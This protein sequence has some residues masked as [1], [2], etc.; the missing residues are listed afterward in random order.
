M[1]TRPRL[2]IVVA[3]VMVVAAGCATTVER[4]VGD[5]TIATRVRT[6]IL[7]DPILSGAVVEVEASQGIVTLTG[8]VASASVADR[9]A[10]VART[11][12]GVVDVVLRLQI[13]PDG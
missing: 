11:V 7:N 6:A 2:P 10:V 1:L 5:A 8:K 3:L 9:A 12:E 4:S 13:T